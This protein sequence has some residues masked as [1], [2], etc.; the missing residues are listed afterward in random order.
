MKIHPTAI[1]HPK[2]KIADDV[3]IGPFCT[4][5]ENVE[6]GSGTRL[7]SSVVIEGWTT[8]GNDNVLYPGVV[9][10][11]PPQDFGYHGERAFVKIGS[12]NE[13]REYVTI[14]RAAT[15]E[16]VTTVGDENL[17][18]GYVHVAHNCT[19]G[20]QVTMANYAGMA[21]HSVI[22]SQAVLGGLVGIHQFARIGRLCMVGGLAKV[23]KDLPPF[24]VVDGN[25][26]R[27]FGTNYRG[28]RRRGIDAP[29]RQ[30]I[31]QAL[32]ILLSPDYTVSEAVEAIR[33]Q[34][35]TSPEIEHFV[36]FLTHPSRMGVLRRPCG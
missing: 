8:L 23:V 3:E 35:P 24:S 1:I 14:H 4:I 33:E 12:R 13:F 25:P 2:A 29:T 19:V 9:I 5:G 22:E 11:V 28:L 30:A 16:G 27:V 15:P 20:S 36:D 10:G 32:G 21:G 17:L 7:M 6:I 34:I 31:K 18:M 26:A